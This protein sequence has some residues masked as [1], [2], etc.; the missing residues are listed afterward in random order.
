MQIN[1]KDTIAAISTPLGIGGIGII[2][3]S[4]K[5][6]L[7]IGDK[8]FRS[9]NGRKISKAAGFTVHYGHIVERSTIKLKN[10]KTKVIDE[11]LVTV[12]RAPRTYTKEDVLEI[13][14]HG[15][16]VPSKKILELV[17]NNGARLAAP[18]EF[19]QRAFLNGRIDLL[20][21]EATLN[22][23]NAKT[24]AAFSPAVY[25]LEGRLSSIINKMREDLIEFIAPLEAAIDFPDESIS[26]APGLKL[27]AVLRKIAGDLKRFIDSADKGI[28][29][30]NGI[31]IVLAGA[32]NVGKSSIMNA[33]VEYERVIVTNI[34]GT[35][36]DVVQELININ[37]MPVR[38]ADTAGIMDSSCV[39]TQESVTRS[40]A[41]FE[42]ADLVL[43]VLDAAR[44]INK[45]DMDV[46][47]KLK[48]KK[49]VIVI[50]KSD[51]KNRIDIP[52]IA[53]MFPRAPRVKISA[54][55]KQGLPSLE[56]KITEQFFKGAIIPED[57]LMVS[58]L[59]QK[60]CL[61][62]CYGFINNAISII[63]DK[64]FEECLIFEIRQALN[65]LKVLIGEN[66]NEDI[67]DN[68][69][70]RFCIGK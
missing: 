15:G 64:G 52:G 57:E 53:K 27:G 62:E 34:S 63:S 13:N 55:K 22:I 60:K 7:K 6:A 21:A 66:I 65:S 56:K 1:L 33:L 19:T 41:F 20:Q 39:I 17:I 42:K 32:A 61:E 67:L 43:F 16:I 29:L 14:C 45:M 70:N 54:L 3:L 59:R 4:G 50:N 35:T 24:E 30:Q 25:Q 68:I 9:K 48:N 10:A 11:A 26:S 37:G 38:I 2:R 69:F 36:R 40:L 46:A 18:G 12:M 49:V 8:V 44:K 28:M 58:N 5:N 31:S 23:I 51:L 47:R